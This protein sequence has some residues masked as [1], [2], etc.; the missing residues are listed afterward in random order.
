MATKST[1]QVYSSCKEFIGIWMPIFAME[2]ATQTTSGDS[3]T[4]NDLPVT[5]RFG[6][7][8]FSLRQSFLEKRDIEFISHA[9]PLLNTEDDEKDENGEENGQSYIPGSDFLCIRC[10]LTPKS[11][12]VSNFGNGAISPKRRYWIGHAKV[13]DVRSKKK[14]NEKVVSV[15]FRCHNRSPSIP[16]EMLNQKKECSVE[17]LPKSNFTR[18]VSNYQL[19]IF[20]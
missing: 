10:L 11:D 3:Y 6:G 9:V 16:P 17:I 8:A 14:K 20:S 15:V 13:D 2:V 19:I 5:F 12:V 4:I 7:G 18:Y 1:K